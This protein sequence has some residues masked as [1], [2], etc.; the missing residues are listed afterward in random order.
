MNKTVKWTKR[1]LIILLLFITIFSVI[2]H[3]IQKNNQMKPDY[4]RDFTSDAP[5]EQK[6]SQHGPYKITNQDFPSENSAIGSWRFWYPQETENSADKLPVILTV[7]ASN[8]PASKY[9]PWFRRLA[10]WGFAVIGTEDPQAGTGETT[11]LTLDYLLNLPD[12]HPL[13]DRLDLTRIGLAGFS[14][15]GAGALAAVSEFENGK[16]INTL[17]TGSAAYPQL[18]ENMG[19]KYDFS[20]INIP[21]FM[22]AGTGKSDDRN[23]KDPAAEYAGVS[24]L[25]SLQEGYKALPDTNFKVIARAAGAE[26]EEML[27]RCDGYLTAWMLY[28]LNDDQEAGKVFLGPDAELLH[29]SNWIDVEKNK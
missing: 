2:N 24:P 16:Y 28:Q 6:Y 8:V 18:A 27:K 3:M 14:Q 22:T 21:V 9:E 1:F 25:S 29:N 13:R 5:M 23:V 26:H 10:S 11:S 20:K 15:G 4:Y 7:N 17:F 12:N 19:W